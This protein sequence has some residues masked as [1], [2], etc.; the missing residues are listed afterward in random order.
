MADGG[1]GGNSRKAIRSAAFQPNAKLRQWR[2][3]ALGLVGFHQAEE[4]F[5][6]GLRNH[7]P[8]RGALLLLEDK[9]WLRKARVAALDLFLQDGHLRVLASEAQDRCTRNIGMMNVTGEQS[10]EICS[11]LAR[12]AATTFVHQEFYAVDIAENSRSRHWRFTFGERN[13]PQVVALALSIQA[14]HF[15]DLAAIDLRCG[16]TQF[17][18]KSLLQNGEVAVFAEDP[19]KHDPIGP[20][21]RQAVRSLVSEKCFLPP[22]RNSRC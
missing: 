19:R 11:V 2:G 14:H 16:K 3:P 17:F 1:I 6:N 7:G 9:E 20:R 4:R 18:F 5:A 10:A 22:A 15:C 12:T 13:R 8:F 21:A